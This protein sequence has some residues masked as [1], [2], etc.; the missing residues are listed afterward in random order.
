MK[1][2]N[3]RSE[4]SLNHYPCRYSDSIDGD[5]VI[6]PHPDYKNLVVAAGD[7]GHGMK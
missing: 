2:T 3:S 7:S 4:S 6:S 5:F 1:E